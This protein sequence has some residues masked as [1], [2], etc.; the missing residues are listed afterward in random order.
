[1]QGFICNDAEQIRNINNGR[2]FILLGALNSS[3]QGRKLHQLIQVFQGTH[4]EGWNEKGQTYNNSYGHFMQP[5]QGWEK[6]TSK[7]KKILRYVTLS[8]ISLHPFLISCLCVCICIRFQAS[9]KSHISERLNISWDTSLAH[10]KWVYGTLR[11]HLWH[12]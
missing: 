10:H 1:M 7:G 8:F 3:S 2:G 6:K 12:N 9:Q 11:G 4:K 5:R